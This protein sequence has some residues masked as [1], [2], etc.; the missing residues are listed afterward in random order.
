MTKPIYGTWLYH[1]DHEP[2]IFEGDEAIEEAQAD[3]WEDSPAK[4]KGF[5]DKIGVDP[6]NTLQVQF[7]GEVTEQ[8]AEVTNLLENIDALDKPGILRLATLHLA[9][10][11]SGKRTGL[12]KLRA[13][14]KKRLAATK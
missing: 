7:V 11:W 13:A 4:C 10:D 12:D 14:M 1:S 2:K 3:G 9:E 6:D 8:A 5:L